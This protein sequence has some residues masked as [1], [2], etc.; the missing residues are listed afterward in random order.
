MENPFSVGKKGQMVTRQA[1]KRML[2]NLASLLFGLLPVWIG[3]AWLSQLLASRSAPS[4]YTTWFVTYVALILPT[5]V[6]GTAHQAL[7]ALIPLPKNGTLARVVAGL[8][9]PIIPTSGL[10]LV[11]RCFYGPHGPTPL[12]RGAL[13]AYA[14]FVRLPIV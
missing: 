6:G 1:L 10:R 11:R 9:A 7:L 8:T 3:L 2:A 13:V 12:R 5:V 4:D 14:A